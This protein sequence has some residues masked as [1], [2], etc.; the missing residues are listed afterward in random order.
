MKKVCILLPLLMTLLFTSCMQ[1]PSTNQ[2]TMASQTTTT[3]ES[4]TSSMQTSSQN[5]SVTTSTA[6]SSQDIEELELTVEDKIMAAYPEIDRLKKSFFENNDPNPD[7]ELKVTKIEVYRFDHPEKKVTIMDK[8][9]IK[10]FLPIRIREVYTSEP[11][12]HSYNRFI[13]D[14]YYGEEVLSFELKNDREILFAN[15]ENKVFVADEKMDSLAV[16]YLEPAISY[17]ADAS[18]LKMASSSIMLRGTTP[19]P[20]E[21]IIIALISA[22]DAAQKVKIAKPSINVDE[23]IENLSFYFGGE[24]ISMKIYDGFISISEDN[25]PNW[26]KVENVDQI[27]NVLVRP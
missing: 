16:A 14:I 19:Y 18:L 13:Y 11:G 2:T 3:H 24:I 12:A 4:S 21:D 27:L 15:Y 17:P 22:F 25:L 8:A 1:G 20:D 26:Y 9:I 23:S 10:M 6:I 5:T 7:P